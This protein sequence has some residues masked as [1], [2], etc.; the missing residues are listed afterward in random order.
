M[1]ETGLKR[2]RTEQKF[3]QHYCFSVC[4]TLISGSV[5]RC[6][7]ATSTDFFL[8]SPL[9]LVTKHCSVFYRLS[10]FFVHVVFY[11]GVHISPARGVYAKRLVPCGRTLSKTLTEVGG[12]Q[13]DHASTPRPTNRNPP[14]VIKAHS[15]PYFAFLFSVHFD[16]FCAFFF[17]LKVN[18]IASIRLPKCQC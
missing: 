8:F 10:G 16:F 2:K 6:H 7:F 3:S 13:T 14:G 4:P 9:L 11:S 18:C 1:E 17:L 15:G 5:T 12:A